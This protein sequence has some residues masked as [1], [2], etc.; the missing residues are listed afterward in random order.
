MPGVPTPNEVL[1][2]RAF[3]LL[4]IDPFF[5]SQRPDTFPA[6]TGQ[7]LSLV[8]PPLAGK[9]F[10][11]ESGPRRDELDVTIMRK[12]RLTFRFEDERAAG[13]WKRAIEEAVRFGMS[14]NPIRSS[15][16]SSNGP[17]SPLSPTSAYGFAT[18]PPSSSGHASP[19]AGAFPPVLP[20]LHTA[21]S[22]T[23]SPSVSSPLSSNDASRPFSPTS[24]GQHVGHGAPPTRRQSYTLVDGVRRKGLRRR[25]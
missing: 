1:H 17:R 4:L 24:S 13:E 11:V 6:A 21:V 15:T 20:S 18:A 22:G 19:T 9:H 3:V 16:S 2:S 25:V 8:C 10:G 14:Q 7:D 5:T 23:T 12:E